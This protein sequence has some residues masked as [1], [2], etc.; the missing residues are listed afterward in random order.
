MNTYLQ[1]TPEQRKRVHTITVELPS[2][3]NELMNLG[4]LK[5]GHAVH[6]A[7]QELGWDIASHEERE[8]AARATTGPQP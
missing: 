4:L 6:A 2:L 5:T 7:V 8:I 3:H 1:W